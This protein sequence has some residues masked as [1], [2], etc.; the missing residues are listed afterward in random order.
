M[1]SNNILFIPGYNM[2]S[3]C[4][5]IGDMLVDTGTGTNEN[6]LISQIEKHGIKRE[7]IS[8]VVN[9]HYNIVYPSLTVQFIPDLRGRGVL[10]KI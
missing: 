8:L 2:D 6:Y 1:N 7:D 9:T 4:Y 5:L 10:A 3:N